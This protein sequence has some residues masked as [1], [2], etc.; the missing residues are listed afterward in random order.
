MFST[1]LILDWLTND[2]FGML[3]LFVATQVSRPHNLIKIW[4]RLK[5]F[6]GNFTATDK[7]FGTIITVANNN[8]NNTNTAGFVSSLYPVCWLGNRNGIRPVKTSFR[9]PLGMAVN[10]SGWNIVW[11]ACLLQKEKY[12]MKSFWPVLWGCVLVTVGSWTLT[13]RDSRVVSMLD[14]WSSSQGSS[15]AGRRWSRSNRGPVA[16]CTLG[17]G[18]LS[19]PSLNGR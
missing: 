10:V 5:T 11:S 18:L 15:P 4:H 17:L 13:R 19:P 12:H 1:Q 9:K 14:F 6:S 8:Y 3:K 16:L 7:T 2:I